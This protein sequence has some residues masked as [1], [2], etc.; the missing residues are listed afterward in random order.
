[1]RIVVIGGGITGLALAHYLTAQQSAAGV[2][3]VLLEGSPQIG[4]KIR[5]VHRDGFT[6][7]AGPDSFVSRKPDALELIEELE[8]SH[9]LLPSRSGKHV[10]ILKD[11][12]LQPLPDGMRLMVPTRLGPFLRSPLLSPIGKLR[13]AME[14]L[15]RG[16]SP[17][18]ESIA[19]FTRRR[20]GREMLDRVAE[21]LMAGIH[22]GDPER[23]SIHASF[24]HFAHME[25]DHGSLV[26]SMRSGANGHRP[27]RGGGITFTS[28]VGGMGELVTALEDSLR[29]R[30]DIRTNTPARR[31]DKADR[32]AGAASPPGQSVAATDAGLRSQAGSD[33]PAAP[34]ARVDSEAH[35]P[36]FRVY[37]GGAAS[38]T[39]DAD[40]VVLT[41][42]A[43]AAATLTESL[44]PARSE[45]L[46]ELPSV[47]SATVSLG[48]RDDRNVPMLDGTGFVVPRRE[49]KAIRGCSWSSTKFEGRAPEGAAL[50]RAFVGGDGA[51]ELIE[52]DDK[53]LVDLVLRELGSI[54][55]IEAEPEVAMVFRYRNGTPQYEVGYGERTARIEARNGDGVFLAGAFYDGVGIPDCVRSARTTARS[56]LRYLGV[57]TQG[58]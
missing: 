45:L 19:S 6:V 39:L 22:L 35:R 38:G 51:E 37:T 8:I 20:F 44:D 41:V 12:A 5:T 32:K 25:R 9:R 49:G 40:A 53:E 29:G 58:R 13:A 43:A 23:L 46:R 47:S 33:T 57:T 10:Y 55:G 26:R 4:G 7:E 17:E 28:L 2:E 15:V 1:M 21:P 11:G 56:V 42:P 52:R 50:L 18:D 14:P 31:I 54:L 34:Q 16:R 30:V 3:C 36:R 48:F 24:S 27:A